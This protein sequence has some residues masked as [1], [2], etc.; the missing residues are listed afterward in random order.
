MTVTPPT[1]SAG[2][3]TGYAGADPIERDEPFPWWLSLVLGITS[4]AFGLVVLI[5]P[6]ET[7]KVAGFLVGLWLLLAGIARIFSAFRPGRGVGSQILSGIVGVL[8]VLIGIACLRNL[9]TSVLLLATIVAFTWLISGLSEIV[10]A[11]AAHGGTR[12]GLMILG[13]VSALI[14]IVFLIWPSLSLAT[15]IFTTSLGAIVVGASQIAF[16]FQVRRVYASS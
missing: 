3:Y 6:R 12:V 14:G 11:F 8:L 9:I 4:I 10:L 15:L 13:I 5:W 16:A 7:L 2:S 1:E